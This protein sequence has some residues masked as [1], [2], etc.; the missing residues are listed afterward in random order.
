M[1]HAKET[2]PRP[3]GLSALPQTCT[4]VKKFV[5]QELP[6]RLLEPKHHGK[7]DAFA[8]SIF[9][10]FYAALVGG[11]ANGPTPSRKTEHSVS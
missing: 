5:R 7:I 6:G 8:K 1:P 9:T 2:F 10:D 11:M 3:T 4:L